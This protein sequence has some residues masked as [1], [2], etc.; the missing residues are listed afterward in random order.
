MTDNINEQECEYSFFDDDIITSVINEKSEQI[1]CGINNEESIIANVA[2]D[3]SDQLFC[4]MPNKESIIESIMDDKSNQSFCIID[5]EEFIIAS[6]MNEKSEQVF[7]RTDNE[8]SIIELDKTV[9]ANEAVRLMNE[10]RRD[11]IEG[12]LNDKLKEVDDAISSLDD[13]LDT[14]Q[15]VISDLAAIR[16]GAAKG[17]TALQSYTETDPTV[18]PISYDDIM[19]L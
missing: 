11:C 15:D 4:I 16:S 2:N 6:S 5:S 17:A 10:K 19:N 18:Y 1:F 7:G 13:V 12:K 9:R 3:R 14:K 8:E